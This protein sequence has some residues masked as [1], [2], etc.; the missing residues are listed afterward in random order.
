MT[1]SVMP[2]RYIR[3]VRP[4]R[5]IVLLL[6]SLACAFFPGTVLAAEAGALELVEN[7]VGV[8]EF[9]NCPERGICSGFAP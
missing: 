4:S 9:T 5:P 7:W 8:S 6:A 1:G 2:T 3:A